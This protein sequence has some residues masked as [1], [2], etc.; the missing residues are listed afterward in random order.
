MNASWTDEELKASVFVYL[1]MLR[2]QERGSKFNKKEYYRQLA[3]KFGR[4]EKAYEFRMQNISYVFSLLNREWVTGLKPAKNVGRK[5]GEKIEAFIAEL[6]GNPVRSSVGF[7]ID[8]DVYLEKKQFPKPSGVIEPKAS[9]G[10]AIIYERSASVKAWVLRRA[11]GECERCGEPAP[12]K[13]VAGNPYLEVH[14]VK[15]LSEGGSDT[16][17]NCVA[18]C[19]NCHRYLHYG[20]DKTQQLELLYKNVPELVRE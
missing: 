4:S 17:E 18:L 5:N 9:Y 12:F 3:G 14:H 20:S 16:V 7:D 15:R 1:E 13:T 6:E 8:V 19:P 2:K 11:S 10:N